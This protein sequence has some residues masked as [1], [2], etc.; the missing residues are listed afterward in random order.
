MTL[1]IARKI[2]GVP[3]LASDSRFSFGP[4][5]FVDIGIK[6][7]S[8][9][10]KIYAPTI[11]AG[12][13]ELFKEFTIGMCV[14]GSTT[15]AYLVKEAICEILQYLQ[16][17]P[18]YTDISMEGICEIIKKVFQKTSQSVCQVLGRNGLSGIIITGNCPETETFRTFKFTVNT[19][20]H[21]ILAECNEILINDG[22]EFMGSGE[23]LGEEFYS[24]KNSANSPQIIKEVI[25][26]GRDPGVGGGIQY[27][28]F[29]LDKNF[30]IRGI[31]DYEI[32][33]DGYPTYKMKLRGV[34][35][36]EG[37]FKSEDSEFHIAFPFIAPFQK[38]IDAIWKNK[39]ID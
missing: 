38:E 32:D 31:Q 18:G 23:S 9:P 34:D 26:S 22:I 3:H 16:F 4:N 29:N 27:G 5:Q 33:A 39:G 6:V 15:N 10:V 30:I 13:T 20:N 11:E 19:T 35:L 7:F 21:P 37:D 25:K 14:A 12:V 36:Y 8:V 24:L 28:E 1:C 17:A 2:N